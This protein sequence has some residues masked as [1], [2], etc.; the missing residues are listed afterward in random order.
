MKKRWSIY[1]QQN[2]PAIKK[3]LNHAISSNMDA[4]RGLI[5]SEVCQ[6]E[7][8]RHHR[9][10]LLGGIENTAQMKLSTR[11]KQMRRHGEQTCGCQAGFGEGVGWTGFIDAN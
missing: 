6:K 10:S 11:Q 9:R 7:K 1:T 2:T 3:E 4:T 5:L 8:G